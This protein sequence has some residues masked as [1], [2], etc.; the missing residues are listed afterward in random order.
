MGS[1]SSRLLR[2]SSR[3]RVGKG[4]SGDHEA[5]KEHQA[6]VADSKSGIEDLMS[7]EDTNVQG[8]GGSKGSHLH[9]PSQGCSSNVPQETEWS[10]PPP[11]YTEIYNSRKKNYDTLKRPMRQDS[12]RRALDILRDFDT[13]IIVDDSESMSWENRWQETESALGTLADV[14]SQY[15]TDGITICFLNSRVRKDDVTSSQQIME[16]FSEVT[17]QGATPMESRLQQVLREYFQKLR[18]AL[19][20]GGMENVQRTIKP[21]NYLVLTDG[22]PSD[23]PLAVIR[24]YAQELEDHHYPMT[25]VGIQFVQIGRDKAATEYLTKLDND[26]QDPNLRLSR[27]IVDTT[28]FVGQLNASM[29]TKIMLGG[30][31][32]RVDVDGARAVT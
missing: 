26:Q 28:P 1:S 7:K 21:V 10:E 15:D 30:I 6:F 31:H 9:S 27:D 25:Q 17:P 14:A 4:S 3:Q 11:S 32:R 18:V 13:V 8:V 29:L 16:A 24:R 5:H 19:E 20:V 12:I 22:E 23:D 2:R